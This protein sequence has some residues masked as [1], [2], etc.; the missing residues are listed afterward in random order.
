MVYFDDI[1]VYSPSEEDQVVHLRLVFD[2]LE[3]ERLFDNME[4]CSFF[5]P[6]VVFLG[7]VV[8][9]EGIRADEKKVKAIR[10]WLIPISITQ[11]HSFHGLASF[12]WIFVHN[13]STIMAPITELTKSK[14]FSWTPQ[15][16]KA[17]ELIK[18]KLTT[19]L[20]LALPNF[21]E[22]FKVECDASGVGIGAILS[23]N[24]RPIAFF[25]EKLNDAMRKYST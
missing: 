1:L 22:V 4:K 18:H 21:D 9:N 6:I 12:Y 3:K 16:Q 23:Q 25:S 10:E 14:T 19:A 8:S 13:F 2:V 17:F 20:V 24:K 5:T 15:A 11:I 7:F